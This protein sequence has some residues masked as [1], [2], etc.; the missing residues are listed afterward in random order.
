MQSVNLG[1]IRP[2]YKGEYDAATLYNP[3][4]FVGFGG[5]TYFC[6]QQAQ[7]I[8]PTNAT[9]FQPVLDKSLLA[10]IDDTQTNAELAW[11]SAKIQEG[12]DALSVEIV[13]SDTKGALTRSFL[14]GQQEIINISPS[15][16][17][18]AIVSVTKEVPQI[19]LTTD[20]WDVQ[21]N[22][23]NYDVEDSAY[24][25]TLTPSATTGTITLTLGAGAFTSDDVGKT[26]SGNGGVAVLTTTDGSAVVEQAFNDATE[27]ASG[28]WAM[29]AMV[30]KNS[31]AT[32]NSAAGSTAS[33]HDVLG[34]N[35]TVA[36]YN[37]DGNV[38]E[39]SGS[40]PASWNGLSDYTAVAK[41]GEKAA[42]FNGSS[43]IVSNN[44]VLVADRSMSAWMRVHDLSS[45]MKKYSIFG[46]D[47]EGYV[48]DEYT[49]FYASAYNSCLAVHEPG[50][51][52]G[53]SPANSISENTW[54]HVVCSYDSSTNY[55][56]V[57][58]DGSEVGGVNAS[59]PQVNGYMYIGQSHDP[60]ERNYFDGEIDQVRFFDKALSAGEV[61]KLYSETE[62]RAPTNK[63]IPAI[64]NSYGQI[65]STFWTDIN[66]A[67]ATDTP[68]GQ[69]INYALSTDSR[70]TFTIV[71][72]SEGSRNIVRDN[73]GTW[74]INTNATYAAETWTTATKQD[75]WGALSEA[76][77]IAANAMPSAQLANATD[78]DFPAT[79]DTLDL[80]IILYTDDA[81]QI[82]SSQGA[83]LNY[84][85]NVLNQG[86]IN[87]TDYE[88]DQPSDTEVR[89][90]ALKPNNLK[91]RVV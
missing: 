44:T 46:W 73:A 75:V 82:P 42:R 68:N 85:A 87:G 70:M 77:N 17:N 62:H 55:W 69:T 23:N 4:D 80:A 26:I 88:W 33:T 58:L 54:H 49:T 36:T 91:V 90:K 37:L 32:F 2:I 30:F 14:Q 89:I 31:R 74:E 22:G 61:S 20:N 71:K 79:G 12:L 11:S 47:S 28:D 52:T 7:G 78:A 19:G 84:D 15:L 51:F 38:T 9:H 45:D 39:L 72:A 86:A 29:E 24:A 48:T 27:I 34:D 43:G 65:D 10:V 57:Y 59:L 41:F 16:T 40:H 13:E 8:A 6:I 1:R 53:A 56:T 76:M 3:L 64:T 5:V 60:N 83:T 50:N 66:S 67:F 25:T 18:A 81:T 35:S 63:S 21:V